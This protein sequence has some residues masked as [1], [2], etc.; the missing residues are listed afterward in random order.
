MFININTQELFLEFYD[1]LIEC[2][3]K[4]FDKHKE[5]ISNAEL[6]FKQITLFVDNPLGLVLIHVNNERKVDALTVAL[7]VPCQTP[8]LEIIALWM[9]PGTWKIRGVEGYEWV[10][11]WAWENFKVKREYIM[12]TRF[13][14][15]LFKKFYA[16][17]GF[18]IIGYILEK[19]N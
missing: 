7:A 15:S 13:P 16:P 1:E 10:T 3:G 17:L 5:R 14:K 19:T 12:V 11:K 4:M 2:V 9:E 6:L 8:W 18:K